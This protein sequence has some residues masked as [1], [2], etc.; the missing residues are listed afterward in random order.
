MA[1]E[2]VGVVLA[3][4]EGR[5]LQRNGVVC[6]KALLPVGSAP[7]ITWALDDMRM[8][9]IRT[10]GVVCRPEQQALHRWLNAYALDH[11]V[12]VQ[13]L[14]G[15]HDATLAAVA[16]GIESYAG[17][18]VVSTCDV[19][20]PRGTTGRLLAEADERAGEAA[21]ILATTAVLHD[22]EPIWV[23]CGDDGFVED[24]G[25]GIEPTRLCFGHI[26]VLR[27]AFHELLARYRDGLRRDTELLGAVARSGPRSIFAV[28]CGRI[29]DVDEPA[30]VPMAEAILRSW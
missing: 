16:A 30:D 3:G 29:V 20:A 1:G 4:G 5:R 18:V 14:A 19:V 23:R 26:R 21:A 22:E 7:L 6:E 27:P 28:D 12:R 8:A 2:V 11:E 24:V 9:G 10:I 25:K 17:E 15:R 13:I